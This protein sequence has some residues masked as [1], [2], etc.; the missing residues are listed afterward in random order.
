MKKLIVTDIDDR[1]LRSVD[2]DDDGTDHHVEA[3]KIVRKMFRTGSRLTW[4][5]ESERVH[6]GWVE[7]YS[8]SMG[9][10]LIVDTDL[11]CSYPVSVLSVPGAV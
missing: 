2:L 6:I 11:A 9:T 10:V 1:V 4:R 8:R 5:S 3:E 7:H